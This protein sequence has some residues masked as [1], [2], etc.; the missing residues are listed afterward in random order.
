LDDYVNSIKSELS[1]LVF[2]EDSDS[3][4]S[5]IGGKLA[6]LK[7]K[8]AVAESCTGGSIS[9]LITAVSG[10]SKYFQGG[11][12]VYSNESKESVLGVNPDSIAQKGAVSKV[13]VEEMAEGARKRFSADYG[14]STSGI[15]GPNG[16]TD[17]KP[18][19][20]VWIGISSKEGNQSFKF[21]FGK[22]RN[23][24][25]ILTS[26]MALNLLRKDLI[27]RFGN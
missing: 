4:A 10:C 12:V 5:V 16:G 22:S 8:L 25:I 26:N 2:G 15:A 11:V 13:V 1:E 27:R 21:Q 9:K 19:G 3:L 14:I 20:T 18:V 7:L 23:R 24:N 6:A 17:L